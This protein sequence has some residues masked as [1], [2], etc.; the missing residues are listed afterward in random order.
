M[1][2]ALLIVSVAVFGLSFG[3]GEQAVSTFTDKRDGKVYRIVKIGRQIWFAENLNYAAKGSVCYG[4]GGKIVTYYDERPMPTVTILSNAEAQANCAKYGRLYN[5]ETARAA[6]PAGTHLPADKE[7]TTLVD[8]VGGDLKAGTK[9]KSPTG[10][11]SQSGVPAGTDEYGFSALPGGDGY[12]D[13]SFSSAGKYGAWWSATESNN[14]RDAWGRY[15]FYDLEPMGR[16]PNDKVYLFSVRCV[17][18]N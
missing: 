16:D 14:D 4:E 17:V 1:K 13:G 8:Y 7:W 10:W 11:N 9:L 3:G 15:M 5:W 6:C 18:D 2:K 12:A